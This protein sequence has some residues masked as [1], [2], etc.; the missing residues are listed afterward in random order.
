MQTKPHVVV[1][2]GGVSGLTAAH[3]LA[4]SGHEVTVLESAPRLGGKIAG[5][6]V[7][8]VAVDSGAESV[9]ARRPE[10]LDLF[11]E[12]G[13]DDRVVH[14]APVGARIYSRGALR[15]LPRNHVMGVPGDLLE[16]ARS[17]IVS[18]AG[19]LRAARDLVWPRTPVR[20]DVPVAAYIGIRLG[21]EVVDRMVE[22]LLGGVYAGRADRLSLDSTLPQIASMAR[23]ERSLLAAAGRARAAAP[24][25]PPAPVFAGLRGGL[26]TLVDALADALAARSG[27]VRTGTTVRGLDRRPGGGW[28][29]TTGSACHPATVDADGVVL[30]APGPAAS[31]LLRAEAPGAARA[32]AEIDYAG[33]AIV[34]LAYRAAAFPEPPAGSGFLVPAGEGRAIKAATFSSVKW[35]WLA[36]ELRAAHPG[37]E[38]VLVRCSIG[39]AGEAAVLQR[40]DGELAALAAADLSAITGVAGPPVDRRVTRWGG[41]LP[42]Y[43]VGHA[44]RIG[45]ARSAVA[46]LPGLALAGAAYDGVGIPACI[47]AGEGAAAEVA[48]EL[49]GPAH[50]A[51]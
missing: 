5:S 49:A 10:A 28:T 25:G 40:G 6:P 50:Q 26:S 15:T 9:L 43:T 51:A 45:R 21:A 12:L 31:R 42:Q 7:A 35:P 44:D 17:G 1:V 30:A 47:A 8:G 3:R 23:A 16:L 13:L 19:V 34:T 4:G 36:E 37:E 29:L 2:G 38:L 39:R 41:G 32:L 33:M 18:P 48:A 27:L 24:A 22:P 11:S 14:P 20:G 46:P